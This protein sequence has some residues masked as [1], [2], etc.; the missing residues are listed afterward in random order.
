VVQAAEEEM[1]YG[2]PNSVLL[3]Y[4]IEPEI[5]HDLPE[6]LRQELLSTVQWRPSQPHERQQESEGLD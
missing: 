4:G 3:E 5:L 1:T 6:D 2:F